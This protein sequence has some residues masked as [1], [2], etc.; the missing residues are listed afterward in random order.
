M[1]LSSRSLLLWERT[2]DASEALPAAAAPNH[3]HSASTVA[4]HS[5]APSYDRLESYTQSTATGTWN[6]FCTSHSSAHGPAPIS[7][8]LP[9]SNGGAPSA[10]FPYR[11][12][13]GVMSRTPRSSLQP[14]ASSKPPRLLTRHTMTPLL[15]TSEELLR[16]ELG[17][18]P[19]RAD[20]PAMEGTAVF[21]GDLSSAAQERTSA[22][23]TSASTAPPPLR[24]LQRCVRQD[25]SGFMQ[26]VQ[27][28]CKMAMVPPQPSEMHGAVTPGCAAYFGHA[29]PGTRR[30][31]SKRH[32][33]SVPD[34]DAA[35]PRMVRR[36]W[37]WSDGASASEAAGSSSAGSVNIG[38]PSS[39]TA[40]AGAKGNGAVGVT[41]ERCRL[42]SS[43]L[44]SIAGTSPFPSPNSAR[45]TAAAAAAS[46]GVNR[47]GL[48]TVLVGSS[49]SGGSNSNGADLLATHAAPASPLAVRNWHADG[50]ADAVEHRRNGADRGADG[51]D[52]DDSDGE[53]HPRRSS[54]SSIDAHSSFLRSVTGVEADADPSL[55]QQQQLPARSCLSASS[56]AEPRRRASVDDDI[57][58]AEA[59]STA[60]VLQAK[61]SAVAIH[62]TPASV[63]SPLMSVPLA[64]SALATRRCHRTFAEESVGF[65][66]PLL[67]AE[68]SS[69][70]VSDAGTSERFATSAAAASALN[71]EASQQT[72]LSFSL[73]SSSSAPG[74]EGEEALQRLLPRPPSST[75]VAA[76]TGFFGGSPTSFNPHTF[77]S[78]S[79]LS[80]RQG[81]SVVAATTFAATPVSTTTATASPASPLVFRAMQPTVLS[82][83]DDPPSRQSLTSSPSS[84]PAAS[85]A[86]GEHV[87]RA[88][89][90]S[91]GVPHAP[92]WAVEHRPLSQLCL[93]GNTFPLSR[94]GASAGVATTRGRAPFA[95]AA[96]STST[97]IVAG[98]VPSSVSDF[99]SHGAVRPS[100]SVTSSPVSTTPATW[101]TTAAAT[102][103]HTATLPPLPSPPFLPPALANA[104]DRP[105]LSSPLRRTPKAP[106]VSRSDN[107][108]FTFHSLPSPLLRLTNAGPQGTLFP[109]QTP[110]AGFLSAPHQGSHRRRRSSSGGCIANF[111]ADGSLTA[112]RSTVASAEAFL[113]AAPD[114]AA[115]GQPKEE[116]EEKQDT[117]VLLVV[118]SGIAVTSNT[119]VATDRFSWS[120]T[121]PPDAALAV[122][123]R[124]VR[125]VTETTTTASSAEV[126]ERIITYFPVHTDV[127]KKQGG[128]FAAVL[129]DT[130]S[131]YVRSAPDEYVNLADL[132][133]TTTEAVLLHTGTTTTNDIAG[134]DNLS[135]RVDDRSDNELSLSSD[136]G[137][138]GWRCLLADDERSNNTNTC[139]ST[140]PLM[141]QPPFGTRPV[142]HDATPPPTRVPVYYLRGPGC[143][144]CALTQQPWRHQ[145]SAAEGMARPQLTT[146]GVAQLLHYFYT[147][148]LPLFHHRDDIVSAC[149]GVSAVTEVSNFAW[150]FAEVFSIAYYA[151]LNSLTEAML[152]VLW[153]LM[154]V[155]PDVLPMW[156][157]AVEW[158]LPDMQ[159]LCEQWVEN[160]LN[161]FLRTNTQRGLWRG[162]RM[163]YV[164]L[165]VSLRS[166]AVQ[167]AA[168]EHPP[169]LQLEGFPASVSGD[170]SDT[171]EAAA[172]TDASL[173]N[174]N[175]SRGN[176]GNHNSTSAAASPFFG[177][178][179]LS[180]T[181]PLSSASRSRYPLLSPSASGGAV[182]PDGEMG[183]STTSVPRT[184]SP[185][186]PL[187]QLTTA[188][189]TTT[190][191]TAT[192]PS[193]SSPTSARSHPASLSTSPASRVV[194]LH[195]LSPLHPFASS[196]RVYEDTVS[197]ASSP[198]Q[199]NGLA[200]PTVSFR[201]QLNDSRLQLR[202]HN[203]NNI[204][205]NSS[206]TNNT[207]DALRGNNGL[208]ANLGSTPRVPSAPSSPFTSASWMV[209]P[210]T[211]QLLADGAWR[212]GGY[213]RLYTVASRVTLEE[214]Q[215]AWLHAE[216]ERY[217][218]DCTLEEVLLSEEE[219]LE[220]L[221][222]WWTAYAEDVA[223]S[224]RSVDE[225]E[226]A[227]MAAML[228]EVRLSEVREAVLA[229][230]SSAE[231]RTTLLAL[232]EE[233]QCF[234]RDNPEPMQLYEVSM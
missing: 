12:K 192:P 3:S 207:G 1:T 190:T 54:G 143:D 18:V 218:E 8:T 183:S 221:W 13:S 71:E 123:E 125:S 94:A 166:S 15:P 30:I 138:R 98:G 179:V 222:T 44:A 85:A 233:A 49:S 50:S 100:F 178:S 37:H 43:C 234:L 219:L 197:P 72:S 148:A 146:A 35:A 90:T 212:I 117:D 200:A 227:V 31:T 180:S 101:A 145:Q 170:D 66:E 157:A 55:R 132:P 217:R 161:V 9:G 116:D 93:H 47:G 223:S 203:L 28:R 182:L 91:P 103:S 76:N 199:H 205:S 75:R 231:S 113:T 147:G 105:S 225:E 5:I 61:M 102:T 204:N 99:R 112:V 209:V 109:S 11:W 79:V 155:L 34:G 230:S 153:R 24:L 214:R 193:L 6:T 36:Q 40:T 137:S 27:T 39:S 220:R 226:R 184:T 92:E 176:A 58:P 25:G 165:L 186:P 211:L 81:S 17:D 171:A 51:V 229:A 140:G 86:Q 19:V 224:G 185:P 136:R 65:Q 56:T 77:R 62:G 169:P 41:M 206:A 134:R 191:T 53:D 23:L 104:Q 119:S 14:T 106:A 121:A 141:S 88:A 196:R 194:H 142:F 130:G 83:G 64:R 198:A 122:V 10:G 131:P 110:N 82:R 228:R 202:L 38:S 59:N 107:L 111:G 172:T 96:V 201:A 129:G 118:P 152:N 16:R 42:A 188:A 68:S 120:T 73:S 22:A 160:H 46:M 32:L 133:R 213:G 57:P 150:Q 174:A 177:W 33:A 208:R 84:S 215:A 159:A 80:G 7:S 151:S 128:F 124:R 95:A 210:P 158:R 149:R 164:E 139:S 115:A 4:Y 48:H 21:S 74:E 97:P 67:S 175:P 168:A 52:D 29:V 63:L 108:S 127:L 187:L 2:P 232:L 156:T 154:G 163:R 20:S 144:E 26:H 45:G 70:V 173:H 216:H 167:K 69:A 87:S 162:L 60:N 126:D 78:E 135:S 89:T 114:H 181:L 195:E 189:A